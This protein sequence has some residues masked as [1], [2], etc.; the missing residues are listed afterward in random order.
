MSPAVSVEA[1]DIARELILLGRRLQEYGAQI[2]Q[3]EASGV[4]AV[5]LADRIDALAVVLRTPL[6]EEAPPDPQLAAET[7]AAFD[8]SERRVID[9]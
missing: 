9:G 2:I 6:P 8:A 7:Q 3:G 4:T 1:S 5:Q